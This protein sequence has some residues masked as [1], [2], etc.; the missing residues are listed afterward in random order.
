M[1]SVGASVSWQR[2]ADPALWLKDFLN[3]A[4]ASFAREVN[5]FQ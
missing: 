2:L 5:N 4:T 1:N 3:R